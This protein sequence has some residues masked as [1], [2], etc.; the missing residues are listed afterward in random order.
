MLRPEEWIDAVQ[1]TALIV[2]AGAQIYTMLLLR[3]EISA[4]GRAIDHVRRR[5]GQIE[6]KIDGQP[7]S[8]GSDV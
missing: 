4:V 6:A 8:D 3:N 5:L 1:T 7:S 2:T